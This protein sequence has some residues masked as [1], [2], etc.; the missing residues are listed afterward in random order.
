MKS[1]RAE[2]WPSS[3]VVSWSSLDLSVAF[4]WTFCPPGTAELCKGSARRL[5]TG[6]S[7]TADRTRE[8]TCH[9]QSRRC[10]P[11]SPLTSPV[12]RS[13][14]TTQRLPAGY[15]SYRPRRRRAWQLT[16]SMPHRGNKFRATRQ[17]Q[18]PSITGKQHSIASSC[19]HSFPHSP[20]APCGSLS[21]RL[22]CLGHS[23]SSSG[24]RQTPGIGARLAAEGAC[25]ALLLIIWMFSLSR[26]R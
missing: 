6:Q 12:T 16:A 23:E 19:G 22:S 9:T 8:G 15:R 25:V 10:P 1:M 7:A 5:V 24:R 2:P 14:F 21:F 26:L 11:R 13:L 18:A 4:K 17:R 3:G 20:A